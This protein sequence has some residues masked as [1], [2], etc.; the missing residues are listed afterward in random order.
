MEVI[1]PGMEE[2]MQQLL[3]S[4]ITPLRHFLLMV[5]ITLGDR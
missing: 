3:L 5:E 4:M 1:Y 2:V